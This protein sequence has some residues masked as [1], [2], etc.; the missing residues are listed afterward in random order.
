MTSRSEPPAT[1]PAAGFVTLVEYAAQHGTTYHQVY[2]WVRW[3]HVVGVRHGGR[4]WIPRTAPR[5]ILRRGGWNQGERLRV[6]NA[7]RSLE[8]W[9]ALWRT[10]AR[11]AAAKI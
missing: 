5:P 3:G 10:A 4:W 1:P 6:I 8:S 7:R 9:Q 2:G 11:A